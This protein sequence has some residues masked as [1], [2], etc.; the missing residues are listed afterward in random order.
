MQTGII[1]LPS[2]GK[3]TICNALTGNNT[4][5]GGSNIQKSP[6]LGI[7]H[8]PDRR[9]EELSEIYKPKKTIQAELNFSEI[10]SQLSGEI[11]HGKSVE[12]LQ[13]M[14]AIIS[15]VRG[16]N[17]ESVPHLSGTVNFIR[18][19]EKINFDIMFF[20]ISLLDRRIDRINKLIKGMR[21]AERTLS[22][23]KI[24]NLKIIQE[25]LEKGIALRDRHL[26][27]QE[28]EA[29]SDT[30]LVSRLPLLTIVNIDEKDLD[31][32]EEIQKEVSSVIDS[33]LSGSMVMCALLEEELSKLSFGDAKELRT[34]LNMKTS[35]LENVIK[36]TYSVLGLVSFITVGS[37]EVR[38]WT[39]SNGTPA[40][41]AARVVHSDIAKGFIRA[42]VVSYEDFICERSMAKIREKGLLRKE[43]KDYLVKDGDIVN[44]LF[45]I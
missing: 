30:F 9:L 37:D 19:I 41:E 20:D 17:N 14:D 32:T 28:S 35:G 44:Y 38:A 27:P 39:V 29:I 5:T 31:Q 16:F 4:P 33:E 3:T 40:Q 26:S 11:F 36:L 24:E 2:A 22:L 10:P 1:G 8:V 12:Y 15:V 6:K 13:K 18:D 7:A 43:G 25:D 34:D 21:S 45:S 23:K 42:E